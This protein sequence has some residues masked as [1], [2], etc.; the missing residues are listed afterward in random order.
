MVK[1][2][3]FKH[4]LFRYTEKDRMRENGWMESRGV[5]KLR[6]SLMEE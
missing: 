1:I 4:F 6:T 5:T 3:E 2:C